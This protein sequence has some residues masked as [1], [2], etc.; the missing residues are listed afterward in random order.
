[1]HGAI[2]NGLAYM[3]PVWPFVGKQSA[4][5]DIYIMCAL[6][7]VGEQICDE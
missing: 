7:N 2:S 6:L 1:M 5:F 4:P 3:T